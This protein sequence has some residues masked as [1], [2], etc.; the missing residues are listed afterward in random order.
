MTAP[1][2][3]RVR[4]R[5][6]LVLTA[7][8]HDALSRLV[9]DLPGEGVAGLLQQ[10]L[11]RAVIQEPG[12]G[13]P[14]RVG[15]GHW[16]EYRDDRSDRVRR[17]QVVAPREADIDQGRISVLSY[18]GAGLVGLAE[19]QSIDWQSPGGD[20]LRLTVVRIEPR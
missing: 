7:A 16:I 10:E 1:S 13:R 11:D 2:P 3:K 8:D 14:A 15:L 5:T 19:G 18:V 17:V 9:G 4:A 12:A 6:D 20:P